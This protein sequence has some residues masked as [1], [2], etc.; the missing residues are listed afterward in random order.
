VTASRVVT[1]AVVVLAV[2]LVTPAARAQV[3]ADVSVELRG[4]A[5]LAPQNEA[6]RLGTSKTV[7]FDDERVDVEGTVR[8]ASPAAFATIATVMLQRRDAGSTTFTDVLALHDAPTAPA[9]SS[10]PATSS[11][12]R[13][14]D[15]A[16]KLR[17]IVSPVSSTYT[18]QRVVLPANTDA[19]RLAVRR[20]NGSVETSPILRAEVRRAPRVLT[21]VAMGG[22]CTDPDA[23]TTFKDLADARIVRDIS[24]CEQKSVPATFLGDLTPMASVNCN[25]LCNSACTNFIEHLAVR[26][27][28]RD[29]ANELH[30]INNPGTEFCQHRTNAGGVTNK[31]VVGKWRNT[32]QE[33][34]CGTSVTFNKQIDALRDAGNGGHVLLIGQSQGGA[35]FADMVRDHWRWADAVSV[36]LYVSWDASSFTGLPTFTSNTPCRGS[37]LGEPCTS[38]G[39]RSV[40]SRP[41]KVLHF[42]QYHDPIPFQN[43]APIQQATEAHDLNVCFSHNAIARSQFVHHTTADAVAAALRALRDAH[44]Q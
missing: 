18:A 10:P 16:A 15:A 36:D 37:L 40:G 17:T 23:N 13:K 41:K 4:T 29:L 25:D 42:F 44:R 7:L 19:I 22:S 11:P 6:R 39:T 31:I 5:L 34:V 2:T 14:P 27:L 30:A 20:K 35:K 8:A 9:A 21:L 26:L 12:L 33:G 24:V 43:G 32:E 1:A 38:M 28:D 3:T